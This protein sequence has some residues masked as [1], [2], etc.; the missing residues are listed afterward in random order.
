MAL[1]TARFPAGTTGHQLDALARQHLWAYGFDFD[2]GTGH[3]VG[4]CLNVH[5]G[6][7]RISKA[8][9]TVALHPGM[10]IS[11]EPG[12]YREGHFGIRIENLELVVNIKTEGDFDILGFESLNTLS[13]RSSRYRYCTTL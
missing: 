4:H 12:Y 10:V 3:G 9:N 8:P 7:Q 11:N 2:H 13:N 5:E 1:A 6:P